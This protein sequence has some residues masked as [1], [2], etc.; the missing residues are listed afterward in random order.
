MRFSFRRKEE[1]RW[2]DTPDFAWVP[3]TPFG[4]VPSNDAEAPKAETPEPDAPE[5]EISEPEAAPVTDAPV[6]QTPPEPEVSE[7]AV[8]RAD[9]PQREFTQDDVPELGDLGA[10]AAESPFTV[11][12][13]EGP[14]AEPPVNDEPAAQAPPAP[15]PA[16]EPVADDVPA[17]PQP[18]ATA[19]RS[20][21]WPRLAIGF[22]QG[23]G[24]YLLMLT[25]AAGL[26]PG[27]DPYLFS[28]LSLMLLLAPLVLLEGL[29]D[30][31]LPLLAAWTGIVAAGL[32]GLGLY[33]HWRIQGPQQSHSGFALVILCGVMLFIAQA[34]MRSWLA[35]SR[36]KRLYRIAFESA[37]SMAG[38]LAV[39]M[40]IA[41]TAW[42]FLGT[43][44][45]LVNVLRPRGVEFAFDPALLT[46]PLV[47]VASA[48]ALHLTSG[49]SLIMRHGR[50]LLM[51]LATVML[52]LMV[53]VG[54]SL[55]F[56]HLTRS[57]V[58]APMLLASAGLLVVGINAS[59]RG[60]GTRGRMQRWPEFAAAFLILTMT[61]LAAVA[62][63]ARVAQHGW[64]TPRVYA[65]AVTILLTCYGL[66]YGGAAL[67]SIGGGRWMQRVEPANFMMAFVTIAG[68]IAL[69]TPLADPTALAVQ[70]QVARLK[71]GRVDPSAFDFTWLRRSGL[72]FGH[73]ALMEMT[74]GPLNGFSP[75]VARDAAITLSVAPGT[76]APTPTEIGAN[77][78]V[79]TP[80]A[81]LPNSLLRTDW[82][83]A[84]GNVP[85][86]LTT[87]TLGCD[88]WFMDMDGDGH[89][90]ILLVYGNDAHWWAS[91]MKETDGQWAPAAT[92][93]SP[94]CR[95]SLSAM[96]AGDMET[97]DPLPGWRDLWV[98]GERL[99]LKPADSPR[100]DCSAP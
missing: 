33:H 52:P 75:E 29:G 91:V 56:V 48:F 74:G 45:T 26:M 36:H 1:P 99:Q 64:T 31:A 22:A 86:C 94:P 81:R 71:D 85:P 80:G 16:E 76:P 50:S 27:A 78:A 49:R 69:A 4:F 67:I 14:R 19:P 72:R 53:G 25:R 42:A 17:D 9:A 8:P 97:A 2:V 65:C 70:A 20:L 84:A 57:P 5:P 15:P 37:W 77:I 63:D 55:L 82:S 13:R 24:L 3:E 44:G 73:L 47:G 40:I 93:T 39:W 100:A 30:I 92:L 68:C 34:L 58:P 7:P 6:A 90:E 46:M 96:R 28:A 83:R 32:A 41:G 51:S 88:A 43:G 87:A 21:L 18:L 66:L 59:Y 98:A 61:A 12:R 60:H 10:P 35:E 11:P 54:F 79:R 23:L 89:N 62:L 38:R 95:G